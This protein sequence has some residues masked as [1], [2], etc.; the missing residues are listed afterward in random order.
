MAS[1]VAKTIASDVTVRTIDE[2]VEPDDF[3]NAING[4]GVYDRDVD[5][6]GAP[7][8]EPVLFHCKLLSNGKVKY[9]EM[10]DF[11]QSDLDEDD[12]MILDAGD[13]IY[14]WQGKDI[15]DEEKRRSMEVSHVRNL[16]VA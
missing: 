13:E 16:I 1:S 4:K 6:P 5:H 3:W 7:L 12:V 8:L 14:L 2:N 15:S 11:E 9:E 10:A